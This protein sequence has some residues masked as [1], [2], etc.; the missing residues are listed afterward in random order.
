MECFVI[1][2]NG[3][4][5]LTII[6]KRSILD[7]VAVLDPPLNRLPLF[8]HGARRNGNLMSSTDEFASEGS[9]E[10]D[11]SLTNSSKRFELRTC[12]REIDW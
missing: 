10:V 5:P 7:V 9:F 3:F 11:K 2:V 12:G 8:I 4:H 6:K 1:I